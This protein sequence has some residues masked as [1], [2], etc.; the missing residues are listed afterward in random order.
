M[1]NITK[2]DLG[3]ENAGCRGNSFRLYRNKPWWRSTR[4]S[5]IWL[6]LPLQLDLLPLFRH[7]LLSACAGPLLHSHG[8]VPPPPPPSAPAPSVLSHLTISEEVLLFEQVA[9]VS[10]PCSAFSCEL[11][12]SCNYI[13]MSPKYKPPKGG[14]LVCLFH[15]SVPSTNA[16]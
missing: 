16:N 7:S 13:F 5:A 10:F 9:S 15:Y 3:R 4:S 12:L 1:V 11:A 8:P 6:V 2:D 14:K